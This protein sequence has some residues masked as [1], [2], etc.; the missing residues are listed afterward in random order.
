MS[1]KE[2]KTKNDKTVSFQSTNKE[3]MVKH[4]KLEFEYMT[5]NK[6]VMHTNVRDPRSR[7]RD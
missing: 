7:N 6:S 4:R 1:G 3:S 2:K 5:I